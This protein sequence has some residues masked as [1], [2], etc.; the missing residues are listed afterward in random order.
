MVVYYEGRD[1]TGTVIPHLCRVHDTA[2]ER[3]DSL[4]IEFERAADW[5]RWGPQEDDRIRV[6][7]GAYDTGTLYV[8][9]VLP[10]NG[11]FRILATSLP[12]RARK[13]QNRSYAGKS[14]GEII[15]SA[16][17]A[18]GM[19]YALFGLDSSAAIPY[20]QQ[21]N[22]GS[23]AFLQRLLR[24]ES[25]ALKCVNGRLTAIGLLYAQ[26]RAAHQSIAIR[27]GQRGA[28]YRRCGTKLR[29]LTIASPYARSTA[30][31]EGVAIGHGS[32]T[33]TEYP[34]MNEMQAGRWARGLLLAHNRS[35]ESLRL[36]TEFNPGMTALTRI[37]V[38][39]E[40]DVS[41]AWL[42]EDVEHDLIG[43]TTETLLYR[44]IDTVR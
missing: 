17:L 10:E 29:A 31:D 6:A 5:Y 43:G 11:R 1:I 36:R 39:G 24:C 9:A 34:V 42:I 12:C 32:E 21:E 26:N 22:E 4:E 37:D 27:A 38:D 15:Q 33:A 7:Q 2:G 19:D 40:T 14:L 13:K 44:C 35:R 41:G 18:C 23:A 30:T 25:A 16:A 20:I 3:C 28:E 8:H